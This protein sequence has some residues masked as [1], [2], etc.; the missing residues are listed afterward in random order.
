MRQTKN[1]QMKLWEIH[2][3]EI[4]IDKK[5]RDDIPPL[6]LGLQHIYVTTEIR[7]EV[8]AILESMLPEGVN[9]KTGRRGMHLWNIFVLGVLRLNLDWDYDRLLEMTNNHKTIRQML[10]FEGMISSSYT[11]KLQTL[12]DN[13]SLLTPE[14]LDAINQVVVKA[15]H[16]LVKKKMRN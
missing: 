11:F 3:S 4:I 16:K 5:S 6:L 10:G 7:E 8:F 1:L 9:N 2:I 15:G 12:K 14:I 13:V